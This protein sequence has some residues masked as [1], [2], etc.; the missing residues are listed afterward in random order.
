MFKRVVVTGYGA[1]SSLGENSNEIWEAL[2][3]GKLGY[4]RV[5]FDDKTITSKFFGFMSKNK[6]RYKGLPKS[7]LKMSPD[8]ARNAMVASREAL[9]MA[10]GPEAHP[11]DFIDPHDFGVLIGTGWGGTDSVNNNNQDYINSGIATSFSSLMSM[12]SLGTG[13]VSMAWNLRGYQNTPI[14]ACATGTMAIGDAFEIIRSGRQ[15][16][17]LAGGSESLKEQFNVWSIDI[18]TALSKEQ[19][20]RERACCPF[21]KRRSG[22]VL[23]EGAAVLCLEEM[24]HALARGANILGEITGY[25][26]YSDARDMTAPAQDMLSR[27]KTI[28]VALGQAN[29]KAKSLDYINLHGTSTPLNDINETNSLKQALGKQAYEIPCSSTKSNTGHLIGAAGSIEAVFCLKA[30][31]TGILPATVNLNEP[32]PECDLNYIPNQS[33]E[34]GEVNRV[35]NLSFGFGGANCALVIEKFVG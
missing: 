13:A 32:D 5:E 35:L 18:M 2:M 25:A 20:V 8:F 10:F 3:Q 28:E 9:K 33:I 17:I 1:V 21:D 22:F 29:C 34:V 15:K 24:D 11:N 26:N 4:D 30:I 14:A 23:S 31:E 6:A 19:D 16:A 27:I 12:H 7:I